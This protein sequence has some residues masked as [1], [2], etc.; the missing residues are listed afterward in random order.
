MN[1]KEIRNSF[2][3]YFQR[4]NH[5]IVKSSSLVPAG[6]AT[7][8][9]TNAGMVPF[10]SIFLG[11]EKRPFPRAVSCQKCMRAGGKQ[12]DIENVGFTARHHTFFEMLGNFSFGDYFKEEAILF[13]WEL[14]TEI[15]KLPKEQLW[16]S[17]YEE[18]DEAALLWPKCTDVKEYR[19]VRLGKE[20]N[21]WKMADTGP[22]GPCSE[23][24]IDQGE[25]FGCDREDCAVGCDCNRYLE[26]WNLVFMQYNMEENGNLTPLPSPSI[27]TGM[28]LERLSAVLQKKSNNFE[29]DLFLPVIHSAASIA[30]VNYGED[31]VKDTSLKVIADHV[32]TVTFLLSENVTP[33]NEKRGYVM[34]R[35]VRRAMRFARKLGIDTPILH[36]LI[37]PVIENMRESYPE[38]DVN[39]KS[40]E[41]VLKFEE[42]SFLS[43]FEKGSAIFEEIKEMLK[44]DG[45][46][47]IPGSEIFKLYDTF[48]FPPENTE[49]IAREEGFE[50]DWDGFEREME[51]QK[52]RA[53][54]SSNV[55]SSGMISAGVG[56]AIAGDVTETQFTG[57]GQLQCESAIL[58]IMDEKKSC[59]IL[60]EGEKGAL[61]L[62]RTP[63]YGESGGQVGDRGVI[64]TESALMEIES[65]AKTAK[66][67]FIHYGAVKKG[68]LR[69]DDKVKCEVS[70]EERYGTMRNHTATHLLHASLRNIL[71]DHVKQSG[72]MVSPG[73]VRFDFTHFNQVSDEEKRAIEDMVNGKIVENIN[74]TTEEMNIEEA[75]KSGATALFDEKY[76]DTVRVVQIG[77]F[78]KE[79]CG[80]TH[81]KATGDIGSFIILSESSIASGVRRIEAITG[82]TAIDYLRE[83]VDYIGSLSEYLKSDD[84]MEK[85]R[86]LTKRVKDLE[87][88]LEE[89]KKKD[90]FKDITKIM[91]SALMV[92]SVKVI[93]TRLDGLGQKELRALADELKGR[94]GSGIIF[95]ASVE[96]EQSSFVAMVTKDLTSRFNAGNIVKKVAQ[97]SGGRGGGRA[98]M[99]QGGTKN[100]N[101]V[102]SALKQVY[103]IV[104]A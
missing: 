17:V 23:I 86:N 47:T 94:L 4:Q 15:Y 65:T 74:L 60:R 69:V 32:R 45:E 67:V 81:C 99:A 75:M 78:S 55:S 28:G 18:D 76:G 85:V 100:V 92:D 34:R 41:T 19:I 79:L 66:G 31:S 97:L 37:E 35:I 83:K 71:G 57:Y 7:L 87:K 49:E 9:F 50:I 40:S 24:L 56:Q 2:L 98:D 89:V 33:S 96:D 5:T 29:T 82:F 6:D 30:G 20:D 36:K 103:D 63:F 73:R 43:T 70:R 64:S 44:K 104:K 21:F 53:R 84:P 91:E 38:I 54:M 26:L 39:R 1:S 48:G 59:E 80:G 93:A 42:E 101:K 95:L 27:D 90:T 46:K 14:L 3:E 68:E 102:D 62:D 61:I 12:S 52:A 88:E 13:A 25:S 11:D 72:S 10:K 77:D 8:L 51:K 22:C 16:V 58:S